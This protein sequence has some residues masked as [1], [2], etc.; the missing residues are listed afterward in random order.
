MK[1]LGGTERVVGVGDNSRAES[2]GNKLD[3][4]EIDNGEFDGGK[5]DNEFGKKAQKTSESKNLFKSKKLSKFKKTLGSDFFTFVAKLAFI[6]LRQ[7]FLKASIL[8]YIDP[9]HYIRIETDVSG[10]AIG[11]VFSQLTLDDLD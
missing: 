9:E 3:G 4:S 1:T 11:E 10:H 7:T 6:K 8:Y 5:V 2:D